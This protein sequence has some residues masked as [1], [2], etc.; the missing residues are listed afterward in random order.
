MNP[1]TIALSNGLSSEVQLE[2]VMYHFIN[3]YSTK[4]VKINIHIPPTI[5]LSDGL[6]SEI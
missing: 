1:T 6:S 4:C 3:A 5:A 2:N